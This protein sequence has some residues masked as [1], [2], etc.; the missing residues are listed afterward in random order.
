MKILS[1]SSPGGNRGPVI[2]YLNSIVNVLSI[3]DL[4]NIVLDS[5]KQRHSYEYYRNITLQHLSEVL[6]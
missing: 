6:R 4:D 1:I 5:V 3:N 2:G